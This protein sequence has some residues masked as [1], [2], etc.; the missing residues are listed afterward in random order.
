VNTVEVALKLAIGD[1]M[2]KLGVA[3]QRTKQFGA[4][5]QQA[6]QAPSKDLKQVGT[7][8]LIM[9][10]A[11]AAGFAIAA[12]SALGFDKQMSEVQAVTGATS[13]EMQLLR[14]SAIEAGAATVFSASEAAQ[15]QA[16]LAKAGLS[17]ADILGGGLTGALDLAAAGGL[18]LATAAEIAANA[19]NQFNLEGGDVTHIA[20]LLA[21][22]ANKSATDVAEMGMALKQGGAAAANMG[23]P[24][25]ET[26][27]LLA[28]F[29]QNALKGSDGGTAMKTMLTSLAGV[30]GPARAAIKDLGLEFFDAS[31]QFLGLENAA[32]QLRLKLGPLSDEQRSQA[33]NTI[34]GTDAARGA[35]AMME[36]GGAAVRQWTEDVDQSGYAAQL[37]ADKN[38]N[39]A[40]DLEQLKGAIEGALIQGG[41]QATDA[42]RALTSG[43]TNVAVGVGELPGPIQTAF[44]GTAGIIGLTTTAIGLYGTFAPKVEEV[45]KSLKNMGA[46]GRFVARHLGTASIAA[47]GLAT[48]LGIAA[49]SMGESAREQAEF[50]EGVERFT[51]AMKDAGGATDE[52]NQ[53]I[54]KA[55]TDANIASILADST[56]DLDIF[57][58][59]VRDSGTE[60][61]R[62][63][64]FFQEASVTGDFE[65]SLRAIA[66]GGN[67]LATELIRMRDAGELSAEELKDLSGP[68]ERPDRHVVAGSVGSE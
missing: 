64:R 54:K 26:V 6:A 21:A 1:Y 68:H 59:G 60:L 28:V 24:L 49:W 58:R 15:A 27:G 25:E 4:D 55:F 67:E 38:N 44:L 57:A 3:G 20:D 48:V 36:G 51:Q 56:A 65:S 18:D 45:V 32:E 7:A 13:E 39:L 42:L 9:G 10:G 35:I 40:G 43:L 11:V 61:D 29:A 37:A 17:T 30:S 62:L 16:E 63:A 31:G 41:S 47:G 5:L 33:L 2:A 50:N 12:H 52:F 46:A 66:D 53:E 19:M 22:G 23:I 14:D 34:F 8:A